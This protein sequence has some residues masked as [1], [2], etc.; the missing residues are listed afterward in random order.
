MAGFPYQRTSEQL[1]EHVHFRLF[2]RLRKLAYCEIYEG[3]SLESLLVAVESLDESRRV[4]DKR[5]EK[6]LTLW[7]LIVIL[8]VK[9]EF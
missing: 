8:L 3:I 4:V 6:R 9:T 7:G 1:V 5:L 2:V